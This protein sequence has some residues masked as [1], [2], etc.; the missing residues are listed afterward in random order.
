M[1]RLAV[2]QTYRADA[3]LT[4]PRVALAALSDARR[5][6]ILEYLMENGYANCRTLAAYLGCSR[7]NTNRFL[8]GMVDVGLLNKYGHGIYYIDRDGI[9]YIA[10]WLQR[11]AD[12]ADPPR[13]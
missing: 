11:V 5:W 7:N 1:P 6:A 13:P 4:G 2:P 9:R 10:D 3:G 8:R 12:R